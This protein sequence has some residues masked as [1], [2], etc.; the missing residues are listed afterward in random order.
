MKTPT[1]STASGSCGRSMGGFASHRAIEAAEVVDPEA[2]RTGQ[3][4]TRTFAER[5]CAMPVPRERSE[6]VS[7]VGTDEIDLKRNPH[8][9]NVTSGACVDEVGSG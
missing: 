4:A 8:Q 1:I 6:V 9:L 3:A 5:P 7:I 2:L